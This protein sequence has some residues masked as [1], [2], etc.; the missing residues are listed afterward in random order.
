MITC[1]LILLELIFIVMFYIDGKKNL[2]KVSFLKKIKE[3]DGS[4]WKERTGLLKSNNPPILCFM[5][6][7]SK[8]R[9]P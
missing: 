5:S 8:F 2:S 3:V 7:K 4:F 6:I 1:N 9:V